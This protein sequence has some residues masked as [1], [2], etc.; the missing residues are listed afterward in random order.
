[1]CLFS[2]TSWNAEHIYLFLNSQDLKTYFSFTSVFSWFLTPQVLSDE[3]PPGVNKLASFAW[4][5]IQR[6]LD[7]ACVALRAD[8]SLHTYIFPLVN[9]LQQR[10]NYN[11]LPK[12]FGVSFILMSKL[13]NGI[14][15]IV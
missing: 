5:P 7:V 15:D 11:D 10:E 9:Q 14:V 4:T 8:W 1:M 3:G 12:G 13:S 6:G 2:H